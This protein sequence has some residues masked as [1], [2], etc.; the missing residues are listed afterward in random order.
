MCKICCLDMNLEM[1]HKQNCVQKKFK[2]CR[3]I[4]IYSRYAYKHFENFKVLSSIIY[5]FCSSNFLRHGTRPNASMG[6]SFRAF[7]TA[8]RPNAV[9]TVS[10]EA[11]LNPRYQKEV[12]QRH[13]ILVTV[14]A[15]CFRKM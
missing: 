4:Y 2:C 1:L 15:Q 14:L 7:V 12:C 8:T 3:Y 9:Q 6:T 5:T 11:S 10:F 13:L